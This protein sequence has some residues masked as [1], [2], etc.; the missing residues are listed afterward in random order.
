[1]ITKSKFESGSKEHEFEQQVNFVK[2]QLDTFNNNLP[3]STKFVEEWLDDLK[4]KIK[5]QTESLDDK[6]IEIQA[7]K[8]KGKYNN[9]M[10]DDLNHE[11]D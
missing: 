8:N 2:S 4:I 10:G 11:F 3:S 7:L 1:M 9:Q 6:L 5:N